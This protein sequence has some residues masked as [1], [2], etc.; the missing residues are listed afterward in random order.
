MVVALLAAGCAYGGSPADPGALSVAG[1]TLGVSELTAELDWLAANPQAAAALVGVDTSSPET[2]G[3][4]DVPAWRVP[5]AVALLNIHA[6]AGL[7]AETNS[8]AGVVPGPEA[9]AAAADALTQVGG[10][11]PDI[12]E[13]LSDAIVALVANQVAL[14]AS[15]SNGGVGVSDEEVRAAYDEIIGDTGQ[16]D[17]FA[18]VSHILVAVEGGG[19]P[20]GVDP[21]AAEQAATD[22]LGRIEAGESFAAVAAEVSD[23]PGSASAGGDLGCNAP[24]TFVAPFEEAVAGLEPGELSGL[25][26]TDF[27]FHV[28]QLRSVG[29]PPFDEVAPELRRQL[30]AERADTSSA[31]LGAVRNAAAGVRVE[32]NPR[33]GS[34]DEAQ[35][36]VVAP[37]GARPAPVAPGDADLL[38]GLGL[39]GLLGP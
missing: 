1:R 20:G 31:V 30:E 32:V 33:F 12:P 22:A 16:F 38:G 2:A 14:G 6:F 23:D 24:G 21:A 17:D 37:A 27:G 5:A 7:V 9:T 3:S 39:E 8:R 19:A 35:L 15:L 29:P 34:W 18:C 10:T 36:A 13:S 11:A 26:R 25:V 28:I 4:P